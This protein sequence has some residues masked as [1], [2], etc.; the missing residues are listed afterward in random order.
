MLEREPMSAHEAKKLIRDILRVGVVTFVDPH[1]LDALA[2]DGL[3]TGDAHN[4]LRGGVVDEPEYENGAWR[5]R[6]RTG[7]ICLIVEFEGESEL[8]VVTAWRSNR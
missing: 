8:I 3:D 1:A 2:D 6:V 5:Y 7:R 4:V